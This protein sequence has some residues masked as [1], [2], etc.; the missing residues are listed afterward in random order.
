MTASDQQHPQQA[1]MPAD[2]P[3]APAASQAASAAVNPHLLQKLADAHG[4][5]TSFQGWDGLP[6]TVAE[7]TLIKVLAAL[8]VQAATN[9]AIEAALVE[10]ELAPWRRMLPPAVVIMQ[11]EPALVPVH[12]ADG[13]A[14]SLAIAL[15]DGAT[16]D[17]VQQDVW[18]HPVEV[19]GKSIGRATFP[20]PEDLPLGWHTLQA[21]SGGVTA[22]ATLVVTPRR[23]TTAEALEQRRGWGLATQL[24]SVR[25]KR[26]WGIGDFADLADL[27]ALSG[28]RGADYV[29]VNPLHAAE[30]VPPVQPSPYSPST[31]RF[32]NPLYIRVEAITELA[33][34]KPRRRATVEKLREEVSGL[35]KEGGRLDRN[36][37]YGAKLE[38]LEMLYH[39]RRSPARQAAFEEFCRASGP[40]LDDFALWSALR[41]DLA[42]DDPLW[43]DPARAL[44][45]REAESLRKKLADRIGFH[46]WLQWICDEQLEEAQKVAL[47]SGMRL[48]V[49]HDLAV[50]VDHSSADAWTLRGV[51]APGTS[52]GAPP[53]MYNQQG[54]D[55]GQPPWHP[56]RLAEA[57]YQP[58]RNMLATV[59]RHAGGIRVDHILGL[60]RLWWIP[61]G[62]APGDGAYV[63]YDHEALIGILALEAQRA[64]AV[65]I[66]ED[67]GTFEPWVRDYL[68]ARGILGTSI[69]WFEY[70][71][72]SPL[73]PEKY[74]TQAL[75]S[76]NTHDLP[77]TAGY[78]AG[79]HV[80]LRSRLGLLERSEEEER[81]EHNASL[82]K[83]LALVRERGYLPGK[84]ASGPAETEEQTIEALHLLLTQ[85]PS[86]LLGVALV[87]A[88][89]ERRVQNQPGTTEALYPN[90]QVPL[91]GPDGI[92]VFLDDLPA[93]AR[94]N[95][96]LAAVEGALHR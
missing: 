16:V 65:V 18:E 5:G 22:S 39:T 58:F 10:A 83:M 77:P 23:L 34:L 49:V 17:A 28:V 79:D 21:E 15:E 8:G 13:A 32:F 29:L 55:W 40:G 89:G 72:D 85:T 92:P 78:L 48:G 95:S 31:R 87:D 54:Q 25:S 56:A 7:E 47:R 9:Q 86:V 19:D 57:G 4:V 62:N 59:L 43:T 11:G 14:V 69:L 60:F 20:L 45:S 52:V 63:R 33:Y 91:G 96:L 76:V 81:A 26:S 73:A 27:A 90:W 3:G 37:V 50:G 53:D 80:A 44:G 64:G 35:N 93:N 51:L 46:R 74:R 67:L 42:P 82:E 94:F 70:D 66:G 71:G 84:A 75:A 1:G 6:H 38:A 88:V 2:P 61:L 36:A 68:A 24:Y 41:E 30:P 12:V